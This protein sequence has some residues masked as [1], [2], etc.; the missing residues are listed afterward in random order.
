MISEKNGGLS[1]F[2]SSSFMINYSR[3]TPKAFEGFKMSISAR[4]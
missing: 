4:N 2:D 1:C 3:D